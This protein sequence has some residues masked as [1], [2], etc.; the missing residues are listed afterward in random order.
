LFAEEYLTGVGRENFGRHYLEYKTIESPEEVSNPHNFLVNAAAEWGAI[1]LVGVV[2]MLVGGSIA[3]TRP[4]AQRPESDTAQ[5]G[6]RPLLWCAATGG[7][8]FFVRLFLLGTRD[9]NYLLVATAVPVIVWLIVFVILSLES[10]KAGTFQTD[11]LPGLGVGINCCLLVFLVQDTINFGVIVPGAATTFFALLAVRIGYS[12]VQMA[13]EG[14]ATHA[15]PAGLR[16]WALPTVGCSILLAHVIWI[17]V[18]V[19]RSGEALGRARRAVGRVVRGNY[20]VQAAYVEYE[21]AAALDRLDS[22]PAAE[23]AAWLIR[24]AEVGTDRAAVI[25]RTLALSDTAIARDPLSTSLHRQKVRICREAYRLTQDDRH[26]RAA[27]EPARRVVQLYPRSPEAHAELGATLLEAARGAVDAE[28]A[29]EAVQHL[30]RALALDDARPTW[31]VLRRFRP[32]RRDE[33]QA[34]VE[35]AA[36]LAD[37]RT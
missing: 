14:V 4:Q 28:M 11:A 37:G 26:N 2:L 6:G 25:E 36:S 32:R 8:V 22:T 24:Y 27:I 21:R 33:L 18:P 34:R 20:D 35:E 29:Q 10:N 5:A 19:A 3:A 23:C 9:V 31:E 30:R 16:R 13:D 12:R 15:L 17:V 7:A 1:G